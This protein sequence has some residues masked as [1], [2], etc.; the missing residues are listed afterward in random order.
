M[1]RKANC[2]DNACA[3]SFFGTLKR[4]V[5]FL[6]GRYSAQKVRQEVFMFIEAYYNRIRAHST[7]DF[8]APDKFILRTAA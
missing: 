2:W 7:I 4:E 3:E 6:N 1:S 8:K 5:E